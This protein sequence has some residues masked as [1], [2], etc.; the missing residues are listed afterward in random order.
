MSDD[1]IFGAFVILPIIIALVFAVSYGIGG[2]WDFISA[3]QV[4][5]AL[6]VC[7][8]NGGLKGLE[9]PNHFICNNKVEGKLNDI[10]E[11]GIDD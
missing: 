3:A 5:N 9:L 4:E 2:G 10:P 11:S 7:S 1:E 8:T 6:N